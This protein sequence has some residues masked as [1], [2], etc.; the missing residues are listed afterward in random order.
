MGVWGEEKEDSN[1][2]DLL[3]LFLLAPLRQRFSYRKPYRAL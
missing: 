3:G 1:R 2:T